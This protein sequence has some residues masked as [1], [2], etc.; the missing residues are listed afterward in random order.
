[1]HRVAI[2]L[3]APSIYHHICGL[4]T[5]FGAMLGLSDTFS[6][7]AT[8]HLTLAHTDDSISVFGAPHGDTIEEAKPNCSPER[9]AAARFKHDG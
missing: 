5:V 8:R 7:L 6:R 1:M 9:C 2:R 3:R 4:S